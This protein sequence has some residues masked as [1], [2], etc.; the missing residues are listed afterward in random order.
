MLFDLFINSIYVWGIGPLCG[1]RGGYSIFRCFRL[2]KE[3]DGLPY[4]RILSM[5]KNTPGG[6][7][8]NG[9]HSNAELLFCA[10][11]MHNKI[12]Y[13]IHALIAC[14]AL[15]IGIVSGVDWGIVY[16]VAAVLGVVG[17]FLLVLG[18]ME[19]V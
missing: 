18:S 19:I 9:L 3:L 2:R 7:S 11:M 13:G 1:W 14:L 5:A 8:E 12:Q 10:F 4:D 15:C 16:G 17:I 6:E